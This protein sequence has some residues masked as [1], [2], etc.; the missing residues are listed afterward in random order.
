MLL[1]RQGHVYSTNCA[2]A[3]NEDR[4]LAFYLQRAVLLYL[5]SAL[6]GNGLGW[7]SMARLN[8]TFSQFLL[9]KLLFCDG[10]NI[11]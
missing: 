9:P 2:G 10:P 3:E 7:L 5:I 1:L 11:L 6:C 8:Q 4:A